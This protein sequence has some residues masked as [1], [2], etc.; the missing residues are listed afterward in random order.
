MRTITF[1]VD[2]IDIGGHH[3]MMFS[4]ERDEVQGVPTLKSIHEG[5]ILQRIEDSV[6]VYLSLLVKQAEQESD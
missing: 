3:G 4:A 2:T 1:I 6:N 5:I